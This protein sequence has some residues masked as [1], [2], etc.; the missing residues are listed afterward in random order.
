MSNSDKTTLDQ[1][2]QHSFTNPPNKDALRPHPDLRSEV[3]ALRKWVKNNA[4]SRVVAESP[5]WML[6]GSMKAPSLPPANKRQT[7]LKYLYLLLPFEVLNRDKLASALEIEYPV[8]LRAEMR[9]TK[10]QGRKGWTSEWRWAIKLETQT[11]PQY[12]WCSHWCSRVDIFMHDLPYQMAHYG[13]PRDTRDLK[14]AIVEPDEIRRQ[15]DP[16]PGREWNAEIYQ[17]TGPGK[18]KVVMVYYD[19]IA[20]GNDLSGQHVKAWNDSMR[21]QF[22]QFMRPLLPYDRDF[23]CNLRAKTT[24]LP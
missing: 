8:D 11:Y 16:I 20:Y 10:R 9:T 15:P 2:R 3:F 18:F 4:T 5:W 7:L 23:E 1:D 21:E 14:D 19:S 13:I 17:R 6:S 12:T 24:I 22:A